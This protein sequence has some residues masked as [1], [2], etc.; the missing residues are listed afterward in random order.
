MRRP[1][2]IVAVLACVLV[3]C[4]D[5][6]PAAS[7]NAGSTQPEQTPSTTAP[8]AFEIP[9]ELLDRVEEAGFEFPEI[10]YPKQPEGVEWPTDEWPRGDI[11]AGVD[12]SAVESVVAGSFAAGSGEGDTIE[13]VLVVKDGR[14]VVEEYN[15]W[16]PEEFHPSWSMAKSITSAM[17]GILAGRGEI[18]VFEPA[19]AP[20]WADPA[21]PRHGITVDDLLRMS[22]GLEWTEDYVD[23]RGDVLNI[24]GG[25]GAADRAGYAASK[26]LAHDPDTVWYYSTGTAN[27]VAREVAERVGFGDAYADWITE[28]LLEPL[29][30]VGAELQIDDAGVINGGSWVTMRP[31]DFARFGY[32]Y[33]RGGEWDGAQVVPTAW[34]DYSRMP[35]PSSEKRVYGAHWWLS[36][37]DPSWFYASGFN[38]QSILVAPKEDLVIVVLSNTATGREKALIVGLEELFSTN[39]SAEG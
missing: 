21:D 18:D 29:G 12:A 33:L 15:G 22:S 17:V 5:S 3:G 2:A 9:D 11:P 38:G 16:D 10:D 30:I 1:A 23:P 37:R 7:G 6:E 35:T 20:E 19:S 13:A 36:E 34:V 31:V 39:E 27:I 32:L 28:N 8:A 24:L 4:S 14:L 25:D 26:P